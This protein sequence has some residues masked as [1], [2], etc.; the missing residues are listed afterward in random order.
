VSACL[1]GIAGEI[2]ED[3][4]E[5]IAIGPDGEGNLAAV[6]SWADGEQ[7]RGIL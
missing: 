3:A 7:D 1:D 5:L 6:V 2:D 4:I